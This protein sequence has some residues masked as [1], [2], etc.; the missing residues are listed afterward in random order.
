MTTSAPLVPISSFEPSYAYIP[1]LAGYFLYMYV[2][3]VLF[4]NTVAPYTGHCASY[5]ALVSIRVCVHVLGRVMFNMMCVMFDVLVK[6]VIKS[7]GS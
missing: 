7:I 2:Y 4:N 6:L 3:C 1:S 5:P